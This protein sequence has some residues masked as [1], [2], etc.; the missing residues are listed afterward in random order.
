MTTQTRRLPRTLKKKLEAGIDHLT[1]REAGRLWAI[2]ADE[3]LA[4][5]PRPYPPLDELGAAWNRRLEA[6]KKKGVNEYNAEIALHNGFLF[7]THTWGVVNITWGGGELWRVM[8]LATMTSQRVNLLLYKDAVSEIARYTVRD[9]VDDMPR[10]VS[11]ADYDRMLAWAES[12]APLDLSE[13]VNLLLD[14]W[15]EKQGF[16]TLEVPDAFHDKVA[17]GEF[18]DHI[19]ADDFD[20]GNPDYRETV[21]IR[22][23]YAEVEGDRLLNE[24]FAGDRSRLDDWVG[25]GHFTDPADRK[26]VFD[27][28]DEFM[29]RLEAMVEAGDLVGGPTIYFGNLFTSL[30]IR[31]GKLPAWAALRIVWDNWLRDRAIFKPEEPV[32]DPRAPE[33]V[34]SLYD[35]AGDLTGDR[36]TA[37][38]GDFVKDCRS[39]PWGKTL[40]RKVDLPALATFLVT[41]ATPLTHLDA[42]DLGLVDW[43]AFRSREGDEGR[44]WEPYPTVT[45]GSLKTKAADLGLSSDDIGKHAGYIREAYYPTADPEAKR[46]KIA[47]VIGR[48]NSL[49]KSQRAFTYREKLQ[50]G[51]LSLQEF[52]GMDFFTELEVAVKQLGEA[53]GQVATFR[54][55]FDILSD[56]YFDGLPIMSSHMRER[57]DLVEAMLNDTAEHLADW[58]EK[59]RNWPWEVDTTG[60]KLVKQG[61]DEELVAAHV[62]IVE[63]YAV[64]ELRDKKIPVDLGNGEVPPVITRWRKGETI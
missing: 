8:L 24:V 58:L 22:R 50:E 52:L 35:T 34:W 64:L 25:E 14:A 57:R 9:L 32:V 5:Y 17:A 2:Y 39:R 3:S 15:E 45:V 41:V 33:G 44:D 51:Q 38:V 1:P 42:P 18:D 60:L 56:R 30:M 53:F 19:D 27:K 7:L 13:V 16:K 11:Q 10:P 26:A 59:L 31:A 48:L 54:R 49:R 43:E 23:L 61:E 55:V 28:G 37:L 4:K 47:R 12:E 36:L 21:D 20:F 46:T 6:A 40:P 63:W 29:S 62:D